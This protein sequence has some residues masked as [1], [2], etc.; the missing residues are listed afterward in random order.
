MNSQSRD[1][2]RAP[3]RAFLFCMIATV[4]GLWTFSAEAG[5]VGTITMNQF[6]Q[7][8]PAGGSGGVSAIAT[9][10][11]NLAGTCLAGATLHWIQ[12]LTVSTAFGPGGLGIAGFSPNTTF[13]DPIQG[14]PIG[15]MPNP[16]P[17]PATLPILGNNTPFYDITVNN[18][19]QFANPANWLRQGTGTVWGDGPFLN[20]GLLNGTNTPWTFSAQTLLVATTAAAPNTLLML[21]GFQWGYTLNIN[22]NSVTPRNPTA[23][24]WANINQATW[25]ATLNQD[26][27]PAG[28]YTFAQAICP[29]AQG[30]ILTVAFV[31]EP[32]TI[33]M[34]MMGIP[35]IIVLTSRYR[36]RRAA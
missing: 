24:A 33:V 25:Q 32:L 15:S 26:F 21:G 7:T 2:K 27:G 11:V 23:L 16:T 3:G 28:T 10:N 18:A 1:S 34:A 36:R 6:V 31:P 5:Q 19:N 9:E 12:M 8:G 30:G 20:F 13:I 17:P 14:Q 22:P 4:V 35:G 29:K